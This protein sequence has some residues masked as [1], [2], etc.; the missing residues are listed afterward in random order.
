MYYLCTQI[1]INKNFIIV[2]KLTKLMLTL[3]LLV[4]GVTGA[5]AEKKNLT[6]ETP[7]YCAAS[8]NAETNT[9]SWGS[10]GMDASWTFMT[11]TDINGDL[12]SLATSPVA[13]S[14]TIR[15]MVMNI[16]H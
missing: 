12:S 16:N 14:G 1:I 5:K 6:F 2:V 10:G 4:M 3:A 11:A 9:L 8:W 15:M 7:W 13:P